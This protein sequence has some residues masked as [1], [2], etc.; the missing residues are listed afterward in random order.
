MP[1][2]PSIIP[3]IPGVQLQDRDTRQFLNQHIGSLCGLRDGR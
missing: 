1:H 3:D 2:T